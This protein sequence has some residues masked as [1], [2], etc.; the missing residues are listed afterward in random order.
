MANNGWGHNVFQHYATDA[1]KNWMAAKGLTKGM[2][3]Y[4]ALGELKEYNGLEAM[5]TKSEDSGTTAV[6]LTNVHF[7][8]GKASVSIKLHKADTE[9]KLQAIRVTSSALNRK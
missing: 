2:P 9:W 7:E 8:A 1:L 5:I 6:V 4:R 3:H